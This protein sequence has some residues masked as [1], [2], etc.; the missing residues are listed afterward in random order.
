MTL[1]TD[2]REALALTVE[3]LIAVLDSIEPDPRTGQAARW[4]IRLSAA[5]PFVLILCGTEQSGSNCHSGSSLSG[6]EDKTPPFQEI[7][8]D[9]SGRM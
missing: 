3:A 4:L 9:P 8:A 7:Y 6:R 2:A 1:E 5:H